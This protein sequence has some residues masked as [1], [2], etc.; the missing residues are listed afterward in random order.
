MMLY[1]DI[2]L[3]NQQLGHLAFINANGILSTSGINEET[4]GQTLS[5]IPAIQNQS[6]KLIYKQNQQTVI[7]SP[8]TIKDNELSVP[9]EANKT[10]VAIYHLICNGNLGTRSGITAN[11]EFPLGTVIN[12]SLQLISNGAAITRITSNSSFTLVATTRDR[13]FNILTAQITTGNTNGFLD[14]YWR[15]TATGSTSR[16]A[17][18]TQGS[19]ILWSEVNGN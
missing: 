4:L 10:Y 9:L 5:L 14:L 1:G 13:E 16:R 15:N 12:G 6:L 17:E 18:I 3:P 2:E 8:I 7:N 19:Y 11:L